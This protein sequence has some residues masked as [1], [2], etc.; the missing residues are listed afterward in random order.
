MHMSH[1]NIHYPT[2][3]TASFLL[4]LFLGKEAKLFLKIYDESI[5]KNMA[6][7]DYFILFM[8]KGPPNITNWVVNNYV[9]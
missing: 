8:D 4:T 1:R 9:C 6:C 5:Y 2:I 3:K 7:I